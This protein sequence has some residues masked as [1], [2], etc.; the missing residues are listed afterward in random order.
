[1]DNTI[2]IDFENNDNTHAGTITDSGRLPINVLKS[3]TINKII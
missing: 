1:L 3:F 2:S